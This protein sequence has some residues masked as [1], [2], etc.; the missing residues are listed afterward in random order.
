MILTIVGSFLSILISIYIYLTWNFNYWK[1]RGV[2]GPKPQPYVG[3]YPSSALLKEGT[4]FLTETD[5]IYRYVAVVCEA[6][7]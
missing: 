7:K 6:Q 4:N 2:A 5:E 3:T 1:R